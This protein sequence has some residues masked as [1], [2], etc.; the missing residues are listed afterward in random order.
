MKFRLDR[1]LFKP[2]RTK[3]RGMFLLQGAQ[4]R[5][6]IISRKSD[7]GDAIIVPIVQ[8]RIAVLRLQFAVHVTRVT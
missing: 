6:M 1:F 4:L 3:F 7:P 2:H 8:S 5:E